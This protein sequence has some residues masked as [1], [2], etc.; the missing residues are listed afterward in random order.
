MIDK[1]KR[2]IESASRPL[3]ILVVNGNRIG[4]TNKFVEN[5]HSEF[6]PLMVWKDWF[7]QIQLEMKSVWEKLLW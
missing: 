6:S 7:Q 5:V 1:K 3:I 2:E 4:R